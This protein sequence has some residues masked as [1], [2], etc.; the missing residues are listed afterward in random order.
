M[1]LKV[2][3]IS[4]IDPDLTIGITVSQALSTAV[5]T[6]DGSTLTVGDEATL[7]GGGGSGARIQV[8]D[9]SGAGVSEVVVNGVGQNYEEGDV[10]TFSSGTAEAKVAVVGGGF[11]PETGSVDVHVE[12]ETGTITGGGSGDLLYEDAIDND[13]GGKILN[14]SSQ[15]QGFQ[16]RTSLEN[17]SGAILQESYIDDTANRI[18]VVNQEDTT[19][20]PYGMEDEDHIVLE[21]KT[22]SSGIPGN[23]IVQQNA[24]GTGDITDIRMIASGSGYTSL[25]TATIDGVRFIG[26]ESTTSSK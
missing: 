5:I 9:I 17:E 8:Q 26:L 2:T 25:P 12:L 15:M 1:V 3:G 6:N 10:L 7:T 20:L 22:A 13:R 24:T 18:Y 23:K 16:V 19:D 21:D 11:A 4:N 14:E